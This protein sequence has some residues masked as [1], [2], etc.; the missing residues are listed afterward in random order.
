MAWPTARGTSRLTQRPKELIPTSTSLHS[1]HTSFFLFSSVSRSIGRTKCI[2]SCAR[3]RRRA[4]HNDQ[5]THLGHLSRLKSRLQRDIGVCLHDNARRHCHT[6]FV[7]LYG[8]I[9][10]IFVF[11]RHMRI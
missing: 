9:T 2:C 7:K 10:L 1:T 5:G 4:W 3:Q 11:D 6:S 8:R